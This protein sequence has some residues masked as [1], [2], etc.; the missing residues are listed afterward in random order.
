MNIWYFNK[1]NRIGQKKCNL[2]DR[3][4]ISAFFFVLSA[5]G[6]I[7]IHREIWNFI[8]QYK[9]AYPGLVIRS[10]STIDTNRFFVTLFCGNSTK[11]EK[12]KSKRKEENGD[13]KINTLISEKASSLCLPL[14]SHSLIF[15]SWLISRRFPPWF[16]RN[17][18]RTAPGGGR[19]VK[20][21]YSCRSSIK[22]PFSSLIIG[23]DN[24]LCQSDL[25]LI[26]GSNL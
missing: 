11:K 22:A 3:L 12:E 8:E 17:Y 18:V 6:R 10:R 5:F 13:R 15:L 25:W 4:S 16:D 1:T 2:I 19:R 14:F 21:V 24:P 26:E 20:R 9:S 7:Q 23:T